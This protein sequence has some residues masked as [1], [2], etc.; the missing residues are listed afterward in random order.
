MKNIDYFDK[1]QQTVAVAL[2]EDIGSGDL[3]AGLIDESTQAI[4]D[5]VCRDHAVI[6]GRPWFDEV[7]RQIDSDTRIEWF[8]TEGETVTPDTVICRLSGSARHILTAERSAL[9]FLQTLS[10]TATVS[11]NYAQQLVHTDTR[12][13][14]TRKTIPG[15]RLAQKYAVAC[16]GADNHR[17]GLYDAILIKE[18]HIMSAGSI[19]Q[20]I[21]KAKQ[22]HPGITVEVETE[23]LDEVRQA[24]DAK[25]DII[26][27]D[28]FTLQM[29]H[30]AVALVNGNAKLEV[31]GNVELE[32]LPEL[33]KTGVDYISSGAITKHLQAVDL[34]MRFKMA[35][36]T[37]NHP[38]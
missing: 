33:A 20:A 15:L 32:Q 30:E 29:M 9:N 11:A 19:A 2:A 34:S 5:I 12:I 26:M 38:E 8:C 27:L 25:A 16:G 1:L 24:L 14:D 17:I 37:G 4:A 21:G 31:S 35:P 10:A 6:C 28:N 36:L 3:T 18:N 22:L 23:N 7:F 13:L